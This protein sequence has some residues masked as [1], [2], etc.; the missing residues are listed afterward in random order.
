MAEIAHHSSSNDLKKS[1]TA[2]TVTGQPSNH[3]LN[4]VNNIYFSMWF[5]AYKSII[6]NLS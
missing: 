3:S 6:T 5:G 2:S 1:G 4:K